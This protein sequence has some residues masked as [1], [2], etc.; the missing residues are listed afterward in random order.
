[1]STPFDPRDAPP[2]HQV[3]SSFEPP[4]THIPPGEALPHRPESEPIELPS[5]GRL[6]LAFLAGAVVSLLGALLWAVVVIATGYNIGFLAVLVGAATGLTIVW[7]AR[8]PVGVFERV[9]AS[10]FAAGTIV[11]GYYVIG[12]HDI[13]DHLDKLA[14]HGG[15][16]VGYLDTD[17]MSAFVHH[18]GDFVQ[19]IDWLWIAIAGFA[20]F[21]VSDPRRSSGAGD[22]SS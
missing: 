16:T 20:A 6:F 13:K 19:P 1:M 12:V 21:R 7:V 3:G 18:F 22:S 14:S 11:V 9:L 2:R 4:S 10:L 15:D 5:G 8:G 17:M